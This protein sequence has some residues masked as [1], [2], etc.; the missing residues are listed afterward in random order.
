MW[1]HLSLCHWI[2]YKSEYCTFVVVTLFIVWS[3]CVR[4]VSSGTST[5]HDLSPIIANDFSHIHWANR[6]Q[7]ISL[8]IIACGVL[9]SLLWI[10]FLPNYA[11]RSVDFQTLLRTKKA[12]RYEHLSLL[13]V[14]LLLLYVLFLF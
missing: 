11:N 10:I 3:V 1:K 12:S 4:L 8:I 14:F 5:S 6:G 2:F 9:L 13:Q 7:A